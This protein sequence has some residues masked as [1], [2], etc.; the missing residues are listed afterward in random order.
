M[1]IM[2]SMNNEVIA[3]VTLFLACKDNIGYPDPLVA[4]PQSFVVHYQAHHGEVVYT[5][6][7][8]Q[9]HTHTHTLV[10]HR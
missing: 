7:D 8:T 5:G 4:T 6:T 2:K 3:W 10:L 9:T 1:S